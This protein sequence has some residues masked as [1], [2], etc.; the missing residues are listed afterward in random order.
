MLRNNIHARSSSL[1]ISSCYMDIVNNSLP[2]SAVAA[3]ADL[4]WLQGGDV[5]H[6]LL[7]MLV[8]SV[9]FCWFVVSAIVHENAYELLIT[10]VLSAV[11][12]VRTLYYV[13]SEALQC[14]NGVQPYMPQAQDIVM[15]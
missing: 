13:V 11:I 3:R 15:S 14:L 10:V 7:A 5:L 12:A 9:F 8:T 4:P 6:V 1:A 2:S